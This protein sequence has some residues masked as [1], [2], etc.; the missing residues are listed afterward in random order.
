MIV[1]QKQGKNRLVMFEL[2]MS[3]I[4]QFSLVNCFFTLSTLLYYIKS[5]L[6]SLADGSLVY[7]SSKRN[8][9]LGGRTV[10]FFI[11]AVNTSHSMHI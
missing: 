2:Y 8:L 6:P 11:V 4:V 10:I 7:L 1:T 5:H 9:R 3:D